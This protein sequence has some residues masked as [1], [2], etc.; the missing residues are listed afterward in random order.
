MKTL[1]NDKLS[2]KIKSFGA[3]LTSITRKDDGREYLWQA[4]PTYWKRHSPVLFPIVGS[5]WDNQYTHEGKTYRMSQ[6]GFA[7][8]REFELVK[9]SENEIRFLLKDDEASRNIYPFPFHLEIG[10]K[11]SG[12]VIEVSWEVINIGQSELYFQIGAHPAFNYPESK[13][14]DAIKGYFTFDNTEKLKYTLI[15]EKGCIDPS[16]EYDLQL[17]DVRLPID[18]QTF[19]NDALIFESNQIRR[20]TLLNTQRK[21]YITLDF[22]APLVGLWEPPHKDS[23]F[24]CIEPWYG[25][26]DRVNYSGDF[27][28]RD[29]MNKLPAGEK[30]TASYRIIIEE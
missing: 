3:E 6:H 29:W 21:P 7:R 19:D 27:K 17:P 15:S 1:V 4:D 11:L 2:I 24:V 16:K 14:S 13:G 20:V 26:C 9:E 8:D 22:D 30:F 10:Y 5:L 12:N 23:P 18:N 28:H 25:R